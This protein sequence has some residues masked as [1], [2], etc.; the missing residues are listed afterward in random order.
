M[1]EPSAK[2]EHEQTNRGTYAITA[3][4]RGRLEAR[5]PQTVLPLER[6]DDITSRS[7]LRLSVTTELRV[8]VSSRYQKRP[9]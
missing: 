3:H 7:M 9:W 1:E 8:R 6:F 4:A 2:D 5:W